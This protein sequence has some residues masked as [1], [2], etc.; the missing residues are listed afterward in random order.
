MDRTTKG[1]GK[2]MERNESNPI[3]SNRTEGRFTGI[4]VPIV[5]RQSCCKRRDTNIACRLENKQSVAGILSLECIRPTR[6][7]RPAIVLLIVFGQKL[8]ATTVVTTNTF[9]C[10]P[11]RCL[12]VLALTRLACQSTHMRSVILALSRHLGNSN[13]MKNCSFNLCCV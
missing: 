6:F 3:Q 10:I 13:S 11:C 8:I 9:N 2:E 1:R 5:G 12:Y 4:F 7:A